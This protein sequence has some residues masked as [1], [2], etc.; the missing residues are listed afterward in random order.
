[1]PG[2]KC[3]EVG[4]DVT[5]VEFA[6]NNPFEEETRSHREALTKKRPERIAPSGRYYSIPDCYLRGGAMTFASA[7]FE[8]TRTCVNHYVAAVANLA[9]EQLAPQSGL[10]LALDHAT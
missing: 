1:M 9:G 7:E 8:A 3:H 6:G 10:Q 5:S 4:Q 2:S